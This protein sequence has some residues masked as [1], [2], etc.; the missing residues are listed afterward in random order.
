MS[1]SETQIDRLTEILEAAENAS[2]RLTSWQN[3]FIDD[4]RTRYEEWGA[5]LR[6]SPKQWDKLEEIFEKC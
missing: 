5:N 2:G 1:L 3:G 6:V 4:M